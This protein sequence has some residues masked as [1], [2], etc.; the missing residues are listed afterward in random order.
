MEG[1]ETGAALRAAMGRFPTGVAIVAALDGEG[2][3]FGLTVNSLTSVSL[4]PPLLLVCI[5][6]RAASHDPLMAAEHFAVSIL[7]EAQAPVADRFASEPSSGRFEAAAWTSGAGGAPRLE[8][9]LAWLECAHHD[10][11]AGG[12]HSILVGRVL[13]ASH[14]EG[15]PLVFHRGRYGTVGP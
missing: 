14:G 10:V 15:A 11:Y 2:A 4:D 1:E 8:G 3:P 13:A 5:D 7:S 12:D 9:A 6:R